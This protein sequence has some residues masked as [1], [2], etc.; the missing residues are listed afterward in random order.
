MIFKKRICPYTYTFFSVLLR[1]TRIWTSTKILLPMLIILIY[2]V[3][4][5]WHMLRFLHLKF[6]NFIDNSLFRGYY[7]KGANRTFLMFVII[8]M[9][10]QSIFDR[11]FYMILQNDKNRLH[12]FT[13]EGWYF[14]LPCSDIRFS[15]NKSNSSMGI[16]YSTFRNMQGYNRNFKL[17]SLVL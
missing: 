10:F 17:F 11:K 15:W 2:L 13:Q 3:Y 1:R 6:L 7:T 14:S 12:S 16:S 5:Q 9:C 8:L 4:H